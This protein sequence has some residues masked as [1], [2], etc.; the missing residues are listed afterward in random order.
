MATRLGRLPTLAHTRYPLML[1]YVTVLHFVWAFAA[2]FDDDAGKTTPLWDL[3]VTFGAAL[4]AVLFI[5]A[6]LAFGYIFAPRKLWALLLIAPQQ[7]LLLY[8]AWAAVRSIIVGAL[9]D[10]S[11]RAHM[12]LVAGLSPV[13]LT[14]FFH[15]VAIIGNYRR[16]PW[17]AF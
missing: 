16:L 12:Y 8:S 15:T 10:G 9:P 7:S 14:A 6:A 17:T 11:P 13:I 4:P 3:S 1:S 2:H 5:V